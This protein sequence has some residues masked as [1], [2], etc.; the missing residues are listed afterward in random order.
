MRCVWHEAGDKNMRAG[1]AG[2]FN[3]CCRL[4]VHIFYT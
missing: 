4:L 2:E 3:V 1:V